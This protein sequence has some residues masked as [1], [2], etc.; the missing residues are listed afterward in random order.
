MILT[1]DPGIHTGIAYFQFATTQ[2]PVIY[3]INAG[4]GKIE[5]RI[6]NLSE[7]F[8]EVIILVN[9]SRTVVE[10]YIESVEWWE[11]DL[12]SRTS[13]SRGNLSFLAYIV[14]VYSAVCFQNNIK[15]HL[16]PAR[17]WKGQMSKEVTA[18][19]VRRVN[20]MTYKSSHLTDAVG[21]G[22]S[23]QGVL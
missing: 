16:L 8:Q 6:R 4:K 18:E 14:G 15:V 23:L 1:V 19:R 11:G 22:L 20:G 3:E 10:C 17:A 5:D 12:I 21:I 7:Q 2:C 13:S 9:K